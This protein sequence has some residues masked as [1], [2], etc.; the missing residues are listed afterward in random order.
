[1]SQSGG[2]ALRR[3]RAPQRPSVVGILGEVLITF[4]VL[5]LVFLGWQLWF[6]DLVF[7]ASQHATAESLSEQWEN[8][9][10]EGTTDS[11]TDDATAAP[12]EPTPSYDPVVM[13]VPARNATFAN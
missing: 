1:M 6:N 2:E 3:P 12:T 9:F 11:P 8:E 10:D 5:I 13:A 7:G 4:G